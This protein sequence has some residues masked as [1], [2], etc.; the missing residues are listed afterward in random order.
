VFEILI[1]E[2]KKEEGTKYYS[3]CRI[4]YISG[5]LPRDEIKEVSITW[6]FTWGSDG[7]EKS[8]QNYFLADLLKHRKG[9]RKTT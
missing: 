4:I 3:P 8:I 2:I 1:K 5:I 9:G 6:R 7:A